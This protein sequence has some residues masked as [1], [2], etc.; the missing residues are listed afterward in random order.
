MVDLLTRTPEQVTAPQAPNRIIIID[1]DVNG[2]SALKL[3]FELEGHDA[4][5]CHHGV[6]WKSLLTSFQPNVVLLDIA[7]V[8]TDG[9]DLLKQIKSGN[10]QLPVIVT[11]ARTEELTRVAAFRLGANDFVPKPFSFLELQERIK[12]HTRASRHSLQGSN[13]SAIRFGSVICD[14]ENR[15]LSRAGINVDL[16]KKEWGVLSMLISAKGRAVSRHDFHKSV[17]NVKGLAKTRCLDF[18]IAALRKK[19]EDD[20]D[21]PRHI[22]TVRGFGYQLSM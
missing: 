13:G 3:N 1:S 12:V 8:D 22:V 6:Q 15:Q 9:F 20:P 10:K 14:P 19:I 7:L 5:I 17:W 11:S 16:T 2:A 4:I 18:Q 21:R